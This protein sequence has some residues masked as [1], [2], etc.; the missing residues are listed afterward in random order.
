MIRLISNT[1]A[2]EKYQIHPTAI[3]RC[4]HI[5]KTAKHTKYISEDRLKSI[6]KWS[7]KA[8]HLLLLTFTQISWTIVIHLRDS[9]MKKS[10]RIQIILASFYIR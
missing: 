10:E 1:D 9:K 7:H 2:A 4:M 3:D 8:V 5:I 6:I